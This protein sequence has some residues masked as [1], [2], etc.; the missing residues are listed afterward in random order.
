[1]RVVPPKGTVDPKN[2]GQKLEWAMLQVRYRE[3]NL[4]LIALPNGR[5]NRPRCN[6]TYGSGESFLHAVIARRRPTIEG[7]VQNQV[8]VFILVKQHEY[9]VRQIGQILLK[10]HLVP[11]HIHSFAVNDPIDLLNQWVG[12]ID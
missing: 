2:A 12:G 4:R 8:V 10:Q 7:M 1:M 9:A 6:H 5:N 3:M 11:V